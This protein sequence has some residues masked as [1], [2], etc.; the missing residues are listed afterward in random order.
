ME[1]VEF[2]K[3]LSN[4]LGVEFSDDQKNV[5]FNDFGP[6]CVMSC[7]GSG[8]STVLLAN[9]LYLENVKNV[10]AGSVLALSFNRDAVDGL[11]VRYKDLRKKLNKS[12]LVSPVF[13]TY[14]SLF[15]KLLKGVPT[16]KKVKVVDTAFY[17]YK[18]V[19]FIHSDGLTKASNVL[20]RYFSLR[21]KIISDGKGEELTKFI[22]GSKSI[23][24][25]KYFKDSEINEDNFREVM[26]EYENLKYKNSEIDFEDMM[27][28]LYDELFI[29]NNKTVVKR[30]NEVFKYIYIDEYQDISHLQ[31]VIMDKLLDGNNNLTCIGDSDQC[32]YRFRGSSP[33]YI[34]DF[35][36][37][38][39]GS[40]ILYLGSNYRCKQN[41]L[42]PVIPL[43]EK[44]TK[45]V[46]HHLE[47]H[48]EGGEVVK[49][50]GDDEIFVESLKEDY[51]KGRNPIILV[52]LN[53]QQ[54]IL[55]DVL[56]ENSVPVKVKNLES[57]IR[58]DAIYK[59]IITLIKAI[60][61]DDITKMM[62][63]RM[64]LFPWIKKEVWDSI[65]MYGEG[66]IDEIVLSGKYKVSVNQKELIQNIREKNMMQNLVVNAY[67]L[68]EKSYDT[69]IKKG[70]VSKKEVKSIVKHMYKYSSGKTMDVYLKDESIKESVLLSN[71][72]SNIGVRIN[73]LHSVKG[74]EY[75]VVYLYGLDND[76]IPDEKRYLNMSESE[77]DEYIEEER[78]LFYV[79]WTRAKDKLVYHYHQESTKSSFIGELEFD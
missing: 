38:Y 50:V 51:E 62:N 26:F 31:M 46:K 28:L 15:L 25:V 35:D 7:A 4:A 63:L 2:E 77:K 18:L 57:T 69:Q 64:R 68:L 43:I 33:E 36:I 48:F 71:Y 74:L 49:L 39:V 37:N 66:W 60:K 59:S 72:E 10:Q 45:R 9:I 11:K 30:F 55:S 40:K 79:G 73:T 78:R 21:S 54:K 22:R 29:Q 1:S 23:N 42:K 53:M 14:H 41:I 19:P 70:Y 24:L 76:I 17:T 8:K 20:Q 12:V 52:R 34:L 27:L 67:K 13:E 6:T 61:D 56:I 65:L 5:I 3:L 47:S 58:N 32:I 44:N 75:D 16:Y